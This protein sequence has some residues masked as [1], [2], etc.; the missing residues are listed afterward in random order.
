MLPL[1]D[2]FIRALY[3][4]QCENMALAI[5]SENSPAIKFD[6]KIYKKSLTYRKAY[7]NIF[8]KKNFFMS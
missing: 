4:R 3:V 6:A 7:T 1:W 5:Y 8:F 2:K